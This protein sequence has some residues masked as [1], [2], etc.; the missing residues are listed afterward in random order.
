MCVW[1]KKRWGDR[2][3]KARTLVGLWLNPAKIGNIPAGHYLAGMNDIELAWLSYND[4]RLE[5]EMKFAEKEDLEAQFPV[6][7]EIISGMSVTEA[8][9]VRLRGEGRPIWRLCLAL[10]ILFLL[11]EVAIIK[12]MP[13]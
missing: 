1:E 8:A 4:N 12:W 6:A 9:G 10:A 13:E 3:H 5:S 2:A 11:V 7:S